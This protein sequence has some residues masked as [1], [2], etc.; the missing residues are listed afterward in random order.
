VALDDES[1]SLFV[2][3]LVVMRVKRKYAKFDQ[4]LAV[5]MTMIINIRL[6]IFSKGQ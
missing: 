4:K 2:Y 1:S 6:I 5:K 3:L